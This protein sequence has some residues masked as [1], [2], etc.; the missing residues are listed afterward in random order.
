V[1]PS[2][3]AADPA[4]LD[5]LVDRRIDPDD[6]MHMSTEDRYFSVGRDAIRNI[7]AVQTLVGVPEPAAVLDLACGH[8]RVARY[9]AAA[10]P[11]AALV[12]CD[13]MTRALP[14]YAETF[15][16]EVV[17]SDPDFT[18][19]QLGRS[20]DLIW[21]GSLMTHLPEAAASAMIDFMVRHLAA[22]G[23]AVFTTHGRYVA[24]KWRSGTF[25]YRMSQDR[26][27]GLSEQFD[28][29][30]Y[31]YGDYDGMTNYGISMTP[32]AWI[33]RR[34]ADHPEVRLASLVER[35]W[36][37]HQDVVAVVR[38]DVSDTPA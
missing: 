35:G 28:A 6:Q 1:R 15:G 8:G 32:L 23:L 18:Q 29:G 16:A 3:I 4:I 14:F 9:L 37:N 7:A 10:W 26:L 36:D 33:M 19:L 31:S 38:R 13:T 30:D 5:P 34:L 27:R 21:S 24:T 22:G 2:D 11:D 17:E 20:F 12:G 25:P